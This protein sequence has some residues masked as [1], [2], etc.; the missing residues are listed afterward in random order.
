MELRD[1]QEDVKTGQGSP[2]MPRQRA[3]AKPKLLFGGNPQ[4]A[5]GLVTPRAG[6]SPPCRDGNAMPGAVSTR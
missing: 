3:A 1:G 4:I 2:R 6:L 5:K